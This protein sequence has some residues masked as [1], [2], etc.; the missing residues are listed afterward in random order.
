M[1]VLMQFGTTALMIAAETG[2]DIFYL[3]LA[4][5]ADV[6]KKDFVSFV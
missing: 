5:D 4:H 1:I 2:D 3:L 6:M